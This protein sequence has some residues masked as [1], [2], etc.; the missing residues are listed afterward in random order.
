[1]LGGIKHKLE[2]RFLV[3]ISITSD[4]Q[5][6]TPLWQKVRRNQRDSFLNLFFNFFFFFVLENIILVLPY[7]MKLKEE[8]ENVGLKLNIQETNI[9]ASGPI[10]LWQ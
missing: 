5:M 8:S 3:E 7:I 10:I 2:S 6:T 1:M 9:M 4:M